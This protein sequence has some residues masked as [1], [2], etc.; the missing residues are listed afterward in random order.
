MSRRFAEKNPKTVTEWPTGMYLRLS[1][2]DGNDES[3]SIANQRQWLLD[4]IADHEDL[5][6]Y[7]IYIDDGVSGTSEDERAGF[8]EMLEDI[9]NGKINCVLVKDLSRPFRNN[10][11]QTCFLEETRVRYNVRFIS[12]RL[13]FIDTYRHPESLNMLSIGFQGMMNENHCRETSLKVRD[14]FDIKRRK[15]QFIGAFAPY[16]YQKHP[17]DKNRLIIDPEAAEVVKEIY[18][19]YCE[20]M[21]KEGI[22]RR[23]NELGYPNPAEYK[24]RKGMNYKNP[25]DKYNCTLWNQR[26]VYQVLCNQMY[27]GHMVQGKQKVQSY[28]VHE[29]VSLSE[30]NWY[31]VEN[32]HEPIIDEETFNTVHRLLERNTRTAPQQREV[33]LLAGFISCGKCKKAMYRKTAKNIAYYACRTNRQAKESCTKHSIREQRL[34]DAILKAIQVQ[35]SLA[36]NLAELVEEVNRASKVNNQSNRL[37]ALHKQNVEMLEKKKGYLKSLYTDMKDGLISRTEYLDYKSTF[38]SEINA[39]R[40]TID[41]L[42][43]EC[44]VY[45]KGIAKDHP[46]FEHFKKSQQIQTLDRKILVELVDKVYVHEDG[47]IEV[48][49]RFQDQYEQILE[50]VS[51]NRKEL[52]NSKIRLY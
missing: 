40:K 9:Q 42:E 20:G 8:Q 6:L 3:Y 7:K 50:F 37:N 5:K 46:Y 41:K 19:W 26:T 1:R 4:Y 52:T 39:L 49:F 25:H 13:P 32:T 29:R 17:E 47:Q 51:N 43:V 22:T 2:E 15:G 34:C 38:E 30:E 18:K 48:Q 36:D 28:K 27:L 16:G 31:I 11:D 45:K 23:L 33:H 10:A 35:V 12:T 14:V 44:A 21:S 24:R